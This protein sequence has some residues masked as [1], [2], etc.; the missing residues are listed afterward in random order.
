MANR[1]RDPVDKPVIDRP[2]LA[3]AVLAQ[4]ASVPGDLL[5]GLTPIVRPIARKLMGHRF[6]A[7]AFSDE[8]A[9]L[10][11]IRI[12]PWAV[13]ELA[14]R[15]E[16]AG[17]LTRMGVSQS[18][19]EYVYA[20]VPGDFSEVS[21]R[22]IRDVVDRFVAFA[23]PI[24]DSNGLTIDSKQLE[25]SFFDEL[26]SI[27]FHA[28]LLKPDRQRLDEQ[29]PSTL[30]LPKSP[31]EDAAEQYLAHRARLDVLCAA[32]VVE[33]HNTNRAVFD[34]IVRVAAGALVAQV[35]LNMQDPG[36]TVSLG[37]LRVIFDAPFLMSVL[38][39][40]NANATSYAEQL[41]TEL[42][43]HGVH[44]E[45]F[46]HSLEEVADNLKAA[47]NAHSDGS[48][49]GPTARRLANPTF[50]TY[51]RTVRA[52]LDGAV[53]RAGV[54]I[55]DAP[56]RSNAYQFFTEK[57]EE[58]V[59]LMLGNF[60]NP[61]AQKRDAAS[62][63][64]VMRLRAGR[65]ARMGHFHQA[66]CVFVTENV[67]VAD[68]A[69]RYVR[70][71]RL[72]AENEVPPVLTDRFLAGLLWV[73][74]GGKAAELTEYRLLASCTAALEARNDVSRKV[75][76]FLADV[77]SRK[78][79]HFR[80][81]MTVERSGQHL[82]Q[83]TLGDSLLIRSTDDAERLL[84]RLDEEYQ[85]R[86][87]REAAVA[88]ATAKAEADLAIQAVKSQAEAS[89]RAAQEVA[90]RAARASAAAEQSRLDAEARLLAAEA[91][92]AKLTERAERETKS[93]RDQVAQ[94]R[95]RRL[96]D[97]LPLMEDAVRAGKA[98]ERRIERFFAFGLALCAGV[99]AL[100][101]SGV[102]TAMTWGVAGMVSIIAALIG[103]A[104]SPAISSRLLAS[105]ILAARE[106]AFDQAVS[107][108]AIGSD[109][110]SFRINWDDERVSISGDD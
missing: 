10:Y 23:S 59:Y 46:R 3:Y 70:K 101:G 81:L 30:G 24:L 33:M 73:L 53:Q 26:I 25:R 13:D 64:A 93:L 96:Q 43:A 98:A 15:L 44:P 51:V 9:G 99:A 108:S 38:D 80:A 92:Q 18:L 83:L 68:C 21:E 39:L 12:S 11:G 100:V 104:S 5:S 16:K 85:E 110:K 66:G 82:M 49:F 52:D 55:T 57:D 75:Q 28:I 31:E 56:T 105:R 48:G 4:T 29:R 72:L 42:R 7:K 45:V 71:Q 19:Q 20:E 22:D 32:F 69:H 90:A 94:E 8:V 78:A 47:V 2:L 60:V 41:A 91:E 102:V 89:E 86:Y 40:G 76:R 95:N 50:T 58:N 36:K 67:R 63:A 87:R 37:G 6:D 84:A 74:Y 77:D 34:L 17:L 61:L 62:V 65:K 88:Q 35:V 103:Y 106:T 54:R 14:P 1:E 97:K 107:R 109:L 27:D 79:E